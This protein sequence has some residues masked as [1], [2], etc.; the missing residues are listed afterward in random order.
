LK[1]YGYLYLISP[2]VG[3]FFGLLHLEI[4]SIIIL[5]SY[6]LHLL[7]HVMY[8]NYQKYKIENNIC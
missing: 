5:C 3:V 8:I 1:F 4:Y 6:H 7:I 2:I